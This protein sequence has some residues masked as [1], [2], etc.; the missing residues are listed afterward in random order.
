[1]EEIE[2]FLAV[3]EAGSQTAAARQLGRSLQSVNRALAALE[4]NVGVELVRR[5]HAA[6]AGD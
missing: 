1:M 6:I 3:V 4:R 5:D 2:V